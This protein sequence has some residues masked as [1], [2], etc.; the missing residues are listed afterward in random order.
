[1]PIINQEFSERRAPGFDSS[2]YLRR[3]NSQISVNPPARGRRTSSNRRFMVQKQA[4]GS[5]PSPLAE[6]NK[7][8]RGRSLTEKSRPPR[9]IS[10]QAKTAQASLSWSP[11]KVF[12]TAK[13]TASRPPPWRRRFCAGCRRKW[14]PFPSAHRYL[15]PT[16]TLCRSSWIDP[17][18]VACPKPQSGGWALVVSLPL[19]R[20]RLFTGGTSRRKPVGKKD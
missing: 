7:S 6:V 17:A 11:N 4:E 20:V 5:A 8:P 10:N 3:Q 9:P 13:Q 1:L 12:P 19:S 14:M 15:A 2:A 16:P 18:D